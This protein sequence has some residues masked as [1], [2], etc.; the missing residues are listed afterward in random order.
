[1]TEIINITD[2]DLLTRLDQKVSDLQKAVKEISDGTISRIENLERTKAERVAIDALQ[3]KYNSRILVLAPTQPITPQ[4]GLPS[5]VFTG[6][7]K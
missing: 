4:V 7:P 5:G 1:M 2:H 3:K 6:F